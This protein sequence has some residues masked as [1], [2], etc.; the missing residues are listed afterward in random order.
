MALFSRRQVVATLLS[1]VGLLRR[2]SVTRADHEYVAIVTNTQLGATGATGMV[3]TTLVILERPASPQY[4]EGC[5]GVLMPA[6]HV[7]VAREG[8][9]H[10]HLLLGIDPTF[11]PDPTVPT[12]VQPGDRFVV[13]ETGSGDCG[14]GTSL[15]YLEPVPTS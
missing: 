1:A 7:R 13:R 12:P 6:F 5:N 8:D 14:D 4:L 11:H 3:G 15:I 2:G 10:Q 9:R